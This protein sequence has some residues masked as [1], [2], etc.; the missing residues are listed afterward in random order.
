MLV[1]ICLG[2]SGWRNKKMSRTRA[3]RKAQ[4]ILNRMLANHTLTPEGLTWLTAAIDPFH[5]T[6]IWPAGYPDMTSGRVITQKVTYT[7]TIVAPGD[8][9]FDVHFLFNPVTTPFTQNDALRKKEKRKSCPDGDDES[10]SFKNM[11]IHAD[12][13][14]KRAPQSDDCK[15][16]PPLSPA[17]AAITSLD[18][19]HISDVGLITAQPLTTSGLYAGFNAI[20]VPSGADWTTSTTFTSYPQVQFP[21]QF[22]YGAF[23]IIGAGYEVVNTTPQLYRG[24]SVTA[25]R[26][27]CPSILTTLTYPYGGP[28]LSSTGYCGVM[29]PTTQPEMA[30]YPDSLTWGAEDG[31][32]QVIAQNSIDNPFVFPTPGFA[33]LM[34]PTDYDSMNSGSGWTDCYIPTINGTTALS[35]AANSLLPFDIS[36]CVFAGLQ[37]QTTLQLTVHYFLERC[38][39]IVTQDLLVLT[40]PPCPYDPMAMEIMSRCVRALP[41]AC[42]VSENPLGEWF[43]EVMTAIAEWAPAVGGALGAIGVPFAGLVGSGIGYAAGGLKAM[44]KSKFTGPKKNRPQIVSNKP[45]QH[46]RVQSTRLQAMDLASAKMPRIGYKTRALVP[47][48]QKPLVSTRAGYARGYRKVVP[49]VPRV[50]KVRY[51]KN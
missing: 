37:P 20:A 42:P 3:P 31:M 34:T 25:F 41:V 33:G 48:S 13:R 40:K 43:N 24:G 50:T 4:A 9:E 22:Q 45:P 15:K 30:L 18:N 8:A 16:R 29:P 5:D 12:T 7:T 51:I 28:N 46:Q 35:S 17:L 23:R 11:R 6:E 49:F 19:T 32:Y 21:A 2:F 36:G 47:R 10:E 27:P 44:N 26:S 38:P 14:C 1:D 39:S